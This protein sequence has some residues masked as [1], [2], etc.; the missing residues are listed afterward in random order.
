[1]SA[2]VKIKPEE[3]RKLGKYV[4]IK[5]V[6]SGS[7]G[8]VY[9]AHDPYYGR[10][11]A[12]KVYFREGM[13][14][15]NPTVSRKMFFNEAHMVGMLQHQNILPIFDAGE[16]NG[17]YYVVMDFI[18]G[19]RTLAAYCKQGN[20]LPIED[21]VQIIF[22]CAKA[23]HYAHGRGVVH[24]DIKPS[25]L[26]LTSESD[27][28]IIDFG[29]ALVAD[30][31]SSMIEGI[32]GSP[33]YMSPEQVRSED[34]TN[35]SDLYSLGVVMYE[36][37]TGQRPY[38]ATNL[39]KLLHKIVYSTPTPMHTLR[40]GIPEILEEITGRLLQKEP[41]K[42]YQSGNEL[43]ADLTRA[44]HA[45]AK[46]ENQVEKQ[47]RFNQL[48]CSKFFHDFSYPEIW[49]VM[50]SGQWLECRE[51]QE[52]IKEGEIDDRF[53]VIVSGQVEV[54]RAGKVVG[55]LGEG[56]CFGEAGYL[57]QA[58]RRASIRAAPEGVTLMRVSSSLLEQASAA[59]QLHFTK[60]FLRTML[61]RLARA[62]Q[63]QSQK[64]H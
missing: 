38:T 42:R 28:R 26:M 35:R 51:R 31:E 45:L 61:E 34:L 57:Q 59:C 36:L 49:E 32:A 29:I 9:L 37:L 5:K 21:V 22:K 18:H 1:M 8:D 63:A 50:R 30:S 15:D 17:E 44:F 40:D 62:E 46:T 23:L 43:A 3:P 7:T 33:S 13:L 55:K 47:E 60:V 25:N 39:S 12:V 27:V 52:I 10:D 48:R 2:N 24:R 54:E 41:E 11:V 56:D 16:E 58:A 64:S 4:T 20:L 14:G 53:Y 6:G 19:A